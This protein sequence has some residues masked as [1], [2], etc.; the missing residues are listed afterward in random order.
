MIFVRVDDG[1]LLSIIVILEGVDFFGQ[2]CLSCFQ[3]MVS[4]MRLPACEQYTLMSFGSAC[5]NLV[6]TLIIYG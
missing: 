4:R 6:T 1:R 2:L 5:V 3:T